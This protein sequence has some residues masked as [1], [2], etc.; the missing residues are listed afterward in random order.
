[1]RRL[2]VLVNPDQL[3]DGALPDYYANKVVAL[4]SQ[5]DALVE[6]YTACYS[7]SLHNAC[8]FD[9]AAEKEAIKGYLKGV[10]KQ[11]IG[12][13]ESLQARGIT[14]G[15]DVDWHKDYASTVVAKA[16]AFKPD[17]LVAPF[18]LHKGSYVLNQGQW[19]LVAEVEQPFLVVK[20]SPWSTHPRIV[21]AIDPF[22][23]GSVTPALEQKIVDVFKRISNSLEAEQHL[24]HAFTTLP[25]TSI[26]NEHL[27]VN[28]K[29]LQHTI[30]D[31]HKEALAAFVE[32]QQLQGAI[33]HLE[34]GEFHDE[35]KE[36][37]ESALIDVVVMG[38]VARG[39]TDRL[40]IGSSV[41]RVM[42]EVDADLLL[43]NDR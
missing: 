1:M 12:I 19:K 27:S 6:L 35:I 11:M 9:K 10:E 39:V 24:L 34:L 8:R 13:S 16:R 20:E 33:P 21:A 7:G 31:Q 14:V 23:P 40:L 5:L 36:L 29:E 2:L 22:H 18:N 15:Y 26:F 32:S 43:I 17:M 37:C 30:T 41:E 3:V 4:A 38:S 42:D 28:Y 25:Q